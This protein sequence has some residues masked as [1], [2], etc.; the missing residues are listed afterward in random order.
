MHGDSWKSWLSRPSGPREI[1][2]V[3]SQENVEIVRALIPPPEIDIAALLRDDELFEQA[4]TGAEPLVASD[5]ESVAAWQGGDARTYA[6]IDGFRKLWLD[7]LEP[8][9]VYHASADEII[10]QGDRVLVLARDR[11]RR[12]ETDAEFE[13]QSGSLWEFEDG[14]LVRVEFFRNRAEALEAAGLSE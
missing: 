11:A 10:D 8:W 1:L 7:W 14:R 3:M 6:G 2:G 4:K 9:T 5:L 12:A 13:L